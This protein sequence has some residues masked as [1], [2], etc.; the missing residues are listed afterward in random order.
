MAAPSNLQKVLQ[1]MR[2]PI[3]GKD[4]YAVTLTGTEDGQCSWAVQSGFAGITDDF[5]RIELRAAS[6]VYPD[7]MAALWTSINQ[8][9]VVVNTALHLLVFTGI[10]GGNG[11]VE[12]SLADEWEPAWSKPR[13]VV[14]LGFGG[15]ESVDSQPAE[16]RTKAPSK[17]LR[18]KILN[19]DRRRCRICGRN[20]NNYTDVELHLHHIR[21]WQNGGVTHPKNLITLCHTCHDGLDPHYDPSLFDS[22]GSGINAMRTEVD[23]TYRDGVRRYQEAM[24][25][26]WLE[27]KDLK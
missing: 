23:K 13:K 7:R 17:K 27:L 12:K 4:Y 18:M 25:N 22:V 3:P 8:S 5:S 11:I 6:L 21:P 16:I 2:Q 15:F 14:R 19:R 26:L 9:H 1:E 24:K 10:L 20:P